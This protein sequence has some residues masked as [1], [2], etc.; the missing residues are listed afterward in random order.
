MVVHNGMG[1]VHTPHAHAEQLVFHHMHTELC[2]CTL[3][4]HAELVLSDGPLLS[5]LLKLAS[6]SKFSTWRQQAKKLLFEKKF[7]KSW[8][9]RG[10]LSLRQPFRPRP[11]WVGH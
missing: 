10:L 5:Q 4:T 1:H 3:S 6:F 11:I 7:K 8:S 9:M 2:T